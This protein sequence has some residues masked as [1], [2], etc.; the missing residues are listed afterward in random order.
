[1]D[2]INDIRNKNSLKPVHLEGS[3]KIAGDVYSIEKDS[4]N[5]IKNSI[6]SILSE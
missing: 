2:K 6:K 1:M 3:T 4:K 5:S